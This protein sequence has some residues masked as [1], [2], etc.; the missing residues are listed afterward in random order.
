MKAGLSR[1]ATEMM[2]RWKFWAL[3]LIGGAKEV[4]WMGC[5]RGGVA[6]GFTP[7]T[8]RGHGSGRGRVLLLLLVVRGG[9]ASVRVLSM[10]EA[11][12]GTSLMEQRH[13]ELR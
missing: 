6:L 9:P 8:Q 2:K 13:D 12:C 7:V 11:D 5:C 4:P 10:D 1:I 3:G